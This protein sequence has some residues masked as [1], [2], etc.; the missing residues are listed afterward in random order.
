MF[1]GG[2]GHI[3]YIVSFYGIECLHMPATGKAI[4][5]G[6]GRQLLWEVCEDAS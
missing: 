2:T 6:R 1:C 4:S 3:D 5:G